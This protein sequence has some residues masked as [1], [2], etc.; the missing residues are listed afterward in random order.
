MP[1]E[2]QPQGNLSEAYISQVLKARHEHGPRGDSY[3]DSYRVS[4]GDK[5]HPIW[6]RVYPQGGGVV[7]ESDWLEVRLEGI[8]TVSSRR[9]RLRLESEKDAE[10]GAVE[11]SPD[12][13]VVFVR[14]QHGAESSPTAGQALRRARQGLGQERS[15]ADRV[16]LRG[17]VGALPTYRTTPREQQLVATFPLGVHPDIETTEWYPIVCF[18]DW[19]KRVQNKG[20]TVGQEVEVVGFVHPKERRLRDG[21]TRIEK[22]IY[23]VAV[24][25]T[26]RQP[27]P[28]SSSSPQPP[29]SPE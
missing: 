19:A 10:L 28:E 12:G 1:S 16:T 18:G 4:F 5:A 20:L 6:M 3:P 13:D 8:T 29:Q 22:Q 11:I 14:Q 17:R 2:Q 23:A 9:G 7:I 27:R 21:N 25:T 15:E 24:R 26:L